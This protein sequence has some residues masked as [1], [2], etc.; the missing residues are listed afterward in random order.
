MTGADETLILGFGPLP[1]GVTAGSQKTATVT[2]DDNDSRPS[3]GSSNN[4]GGNT[5]G[6]S[7]GGGGSSNTGGN[8]PV[9]D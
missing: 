5:G 1:S 2:I 4:N 6:N 8:T 7:G 3:S 9:Q